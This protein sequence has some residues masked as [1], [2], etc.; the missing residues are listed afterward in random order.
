ME[1]SFEP[2]PSFA[3]E[4][5]YEEQLDRWFGERANVRFHRTLRCRPVD[6]LPE[7]LRATRPLPEGI[8]DVDRRFVTRARPTPTSGWTPTTTR[9]TCAWSAA[10]SRRACRSARCSPSA[11]TAASSPA[12]TRARSPAT[13]PSP[14]WTRPRPARHS[15]RAAGR[16]AATRPLRRPDP[17]VSSAS[18]LAFL[19]RALKAPAAARAAQAGRPG[20]RGGVELRALRRSPALHRG[21]LPRRLRRR[22]EDQA[23]ALPRQKDA[24]GVRLHVPALRPEDARP[25]PRPARRS[26]PPVSEIRSGGPDQPTPRALPPASSSRTPLEASGLAR[27]C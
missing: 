14:R 6:R 17:G 26:P 21:R 5:D 27:E 19:F 8:P 13:A 25:P 7:E 9:S 22:G 12:A 15:A 18:E 11:S 10:A 20:P 4:L 23:R 3:N 16:D 1:T 2:G 24:R